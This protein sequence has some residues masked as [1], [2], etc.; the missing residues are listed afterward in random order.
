MVSRRWCRFRRTKTTR[1]WTLSVAGEG[2][3]IEANYHDK[4]CVEA[5]NPA[6]ANQQKV[7]R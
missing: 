4:G 7:H 1:H 2:I 6:G 3:G 5:V